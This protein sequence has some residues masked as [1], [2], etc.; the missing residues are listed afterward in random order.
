MALSGLK[1]VDF[2]Q[3][4]HQF[5]GLVLDFV[6]FVWMV[7]DFVFAVSVWKL[8]FWSLDLGCYSSI[9]MSG[10]WAILDESVG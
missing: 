9:H 5:S 6:V 1:D 4:V 7:S 8:G 3:P 2:P 10:I